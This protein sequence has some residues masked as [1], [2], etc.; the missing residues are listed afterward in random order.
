MN[1]LVLKKI[2]YWKKLVTETIL[3]MLIVAAA[4][5]VMRLIGRDTLGEAVIAM[6]YLVPVAW[7]AA[8]WGQLPGMAAA[9][10]AALAFDFFFIPP[11]LTFVVGSLESW[12]VLVIFLGV[13]T[14]V[15]GRIQASLSTARDAVL[16]YELSAGLT[17]LRTQEAVAHTA[18]RLFRQFFQAAQVGVVTYAPPAGN[19]GPAPSTPAAPVAPVAPVTVWEPASPKKDTRPDRVLP[20]L[21]DWGLAGEI[22]LWSGDYGLLPAEDSRLMKNLAWQVAKA[23]ER[24]QAL[25]RA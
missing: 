18:A 13:A 2:S 9:L 17:G 25:P 22:S 21:N 20:L 24:T 3:A 5:V 7:C 11:F 4:T 6:L 14:V 19:L 15:V 12:L 10:T 1:K 8:R 23:L 16:M